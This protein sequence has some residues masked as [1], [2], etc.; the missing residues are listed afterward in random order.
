MEEKDP[1]IVWSSK[2]E[3]YLSEEWKEK[4]KEALKRAGYECQRCGEQGKILQCHHR[5]YTRLYNERPEDLVVLCVDCHK[6]ADRQREKGNAY[7][8]YMSKKYGNGEG[9]DPCL[10]DEYTRDEFEDWLERKE[11]Y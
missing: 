7:E 11:Q 4:R 10:D 5:T 8:T 9:Y 6:Q 2:K 3:Y 1:K